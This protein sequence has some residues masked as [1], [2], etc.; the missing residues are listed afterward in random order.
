M[1]KASAKLAICG[2]EPAVAK[3]RMKPW[4]PVDDVARQMVTASLDAGTFTIGA[5]YKAPDTEFA[6]WAGLAR[7]LDHPEWL[8]DPRLGT[9]A[10][11]DEHSGSARNPG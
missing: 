3:G 10:G 11:R 2:G 1:A 8:R 9:P 6:E 4:P 5:N 7:A